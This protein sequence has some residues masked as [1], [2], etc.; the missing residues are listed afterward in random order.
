MRI[1]QP[2]KQLKGWAISSND[3]RRNLPRQMYLFSAF[4]KDL[5]SFG[6]SQQGLYMNSHY[7]NQSLI[8][9][10]TGQ[11]CWNPGQLTGKKGLIMNI[12]TELVS[13]QANRTLICVCCSGKIRPPKLRNLNGMGSVIK[14]RLMGHNSVKFFSEQSQCI[15]PPTIPM[16]KSWLVEDA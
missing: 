12:M 4:L 11:D 15:I 5:W 16:R 10:H 1:K 7:S 9:S 8:G 3:A 13:K 2:D 6:G 14:T